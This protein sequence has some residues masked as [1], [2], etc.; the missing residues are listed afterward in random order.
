MC[1]ADAIQRGHPRFHT[2]AERLEG[3]RPAGGLPPEGG[4]QRGTHG[5]PSS[6]RQVQGAWT[7]LVGSSHSELSPMNCPHAGCRLPDDQGVPSSSGPRCEHRPAVP[8]ARGALFLMEEIPSC[9]GGPLSSQRHQDSTAVKASQEESKQPEA[10][11]RPHV[12]TEATRTL[13]LVA[14]HPLS[15]GGQAAGL[16]LPTHTPATGRPPGTPLGRNRS[17][18]KGGEEGT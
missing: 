11:Q 3:Q 8:A 10:G 15:P 9:T 13:L 17:V 16:C 2:K 1:L 6:I 18:E 12:G 4:Q 5:F 7:A 14:P